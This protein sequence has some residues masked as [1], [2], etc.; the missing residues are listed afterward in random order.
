MKKIQKKI[1]KLS[2]LVG[3]LRERLYICSDVCDEAADFAR[4]IQRVIDEIKE[5]D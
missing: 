4:K 5:G 2:F 1:N 3:E